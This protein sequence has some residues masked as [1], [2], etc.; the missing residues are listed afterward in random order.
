MLQFVG[1]CRAVWPRRVKLEDE[2]H[3]PTV[4]PFELE[5]NPHCL[6]DLCD[7]VLVDP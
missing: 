2:L 1:S 4:P 6:L 3:L 5:D 7:I